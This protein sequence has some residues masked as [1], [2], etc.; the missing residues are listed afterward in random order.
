MSATCNPKV[1]RTAQT[2]DLVRQ[3]LLRDYVKPGKPARA[4]GAVHKQLWDLRRK[5]K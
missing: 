2:D 3:F 5:R 1:Q 4:K